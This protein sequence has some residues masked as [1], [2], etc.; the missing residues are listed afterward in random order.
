MKLHELSF[1]SS[2][3]RREI[4]MEWLGRLVSGPV[5][6]YLNRS[7]SLTHLVDVVLKGFTFWYWLKNG[8]IERYFFAACF[9]VFNLICIALFVHFIS[10][11]RITL[12]RS[13]ATH[14]RFQDSYYMNFEESTCFTTVLSMFDVCLISHCCPWA[15]GGEMWWKIAAWKSIS[16]SFT[17]VIAKLICYHVIRLCTN[18]RVLC[19]AIYL[20]I[21]ICLIA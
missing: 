19:N 11:F 8:K 20:F 4:T 12:S 10:G 18:G 6:H 16:L 21:L 3:F 14:I 7:S 9:S 15:G 1:N 13:E 5:L 2:C 17:R